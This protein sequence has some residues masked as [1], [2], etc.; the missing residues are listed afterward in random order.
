MKNENG[1][2]VPLMPQGGLTG[3]QNGNPKLGDD[4]AIIRDTPFTFAVRISDHR[5]VH[6]YYGGTS[7]AELNTADNITGVGGFYLGSR[8][9]PS[10]EHKINIRVKEFI[11]TIGTMTTIEIQDTIKW[12]NAK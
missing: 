8:N 3:L 5:Q 4:N 9:E 1:Q 2:A 6:L 7:R 12:L 11:R 10:A